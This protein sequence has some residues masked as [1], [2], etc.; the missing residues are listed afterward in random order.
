MDDANELSFDIPASTT[1]QPCSGCSAGLEGR[2]WEWQ[3]KALCTTCGQ[4]LEQ[5][6]ATAKKA[7]SFPRALLLGGGTA[8]GCGIA[9]A[10]FV[11]VTDY[12]L[13]LITIGIAYLVAR[14]VRHA[15]RGFG[16]LRYQLLA[17]ALTYL[18]ST[19]GY[20]PALWSALQ[21]PSS[22]ASGDAAQVGN[23]PRAPEPVGIGDAAADTGA[24]TEPAAASEPVSLLG[25]VFALVVFSL[26]V[27]ASPFLLIADAPIGFLIVCFGLW[28][29]WRQLKPI[30]IALAGPFLL[31]DAP[32]PQPQVA[33]A[34]AE[35]V[36]AN[37]PP[38]D[39]P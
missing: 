13:A 11:A 37:T 35:S 18:A 23:D 12:Q 36:A 7:A 39:A 28:E 25:L 14:V 3:G 2:Y 16:G 6:L 19:M 30:T 27:L 15:S 21:Q 31:A 10:I 4:S 32:P 33:D 38:T 5:E 22:E 26:V 1:S 17:V 9:Y 24:P 8:I 20:A 29:A 34:P